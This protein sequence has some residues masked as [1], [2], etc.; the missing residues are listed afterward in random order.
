[1]SLKKKIG[2]D[3]NQESMK[4]YK[5]LATLLIIATKSII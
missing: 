5:N 1:M 4:S 2:N 3:E